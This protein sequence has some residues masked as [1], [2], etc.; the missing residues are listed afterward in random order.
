MN[1]LEFRTQYKRLREVHPNVFQSEE[2]MK[3]TWNA[4]NDMPIEWF[5]KQVDRIVSAHSIFDDKYDLREAA[6]G[7]RR[8]IKS[9]E[10]ADNVIKMSDIASGKCTDKGFQSILEKYGVNSIAEAVEKSRKANF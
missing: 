9:K 3:A 8:A 7:E 5:T 1:D 6:I 10:F 2:K 4:V